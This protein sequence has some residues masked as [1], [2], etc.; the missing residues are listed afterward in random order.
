MQIPILE[1][2]HPLR[3]AAGEHLVHEAII[4]GC[5]VAR[6]DAF[7][8]IPVLD[9]DLLEDVPVLRGCCKHAGAPSW[10]MGM[11]SVQLLYHVSPTQST[12]SSAFPEAH[13]LTSLT[14]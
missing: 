8:P 9:K 6:L 11:W 4:V 5:I 14:L 10:G 12:S 3:I 7:K 13:S 2:P 1:I